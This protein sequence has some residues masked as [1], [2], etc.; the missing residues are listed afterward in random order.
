MCIRDSFD[1]PLERFVARR[2]AA[3]QAQGLKNDAIYARLAE[4]ITSRR[5]PAPSLTARQIR[6]LI[7]G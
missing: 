7:Y 5:F 4:E 2:H 1:D 3:L 6:R